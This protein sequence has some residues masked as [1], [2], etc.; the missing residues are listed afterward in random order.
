[1]FSE[2]DFA[3]M[4]RALA[5]AEQAMFT[6][7]PNPRV[8]CVIVQDERVI[9]EGFTQP[10]GQDHAEVQAMKDAR[11]RGET[12]R[13]ATAYVTLEPCSHYGRT[14]PCAKGLIE[15]GVKRVIAAMEDPN[16]VVA[17]RGLAML[18]D[19]GV[20]VRCGLL[21]QEAREMNIGFVARMTRGTPWVRLK[22]AASLDGK[23]AL[24]NGASQWITG[25]AARADGHAWRA[26]ACAILTGI[27][28]VREDDPSLTVREV[29]TTRQPLRIV[30]DSHLDIS[31]AARV[32]ADGNALVVCAD[33]DAARVARL[34][35][36][37]VEV[38]DLPNANGKVELPALLRVL[39]ERQLNEIHVEAGYKLNGSLLREHCV[40]ELL[41]YFAP[42]IL[43]DAQGMFHLPA[44]S[45]LDDKLTFRFTDVRTIDND[46][47]VMARLVQH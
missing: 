5:L 15:A 1:M 14:P 20:D 43:G 31:P 29:Q 40:D 33:G 7:T 17:G 30:V 36:L 18:R 37:G 38:L 42:C 47:R 10:A 22:V 44:L 12:L 13:G 35:D 34:R 45:S 6:T 19:A 3:H 25:A 39:G 28:T 21:E 9:G 8:G 24:N 26:R 16:P 27:G 46:L 32:L 2:Q 23:T 11:A 4:R 41:A